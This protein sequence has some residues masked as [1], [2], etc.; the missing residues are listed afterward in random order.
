MRRLLLALMLGALAT[1]VWAQQDQPPLQCRYDASGRVDYQACLDASAPGTPW[2]ML[3]HINLGTRAFLN[4]DHA[5][6]VRH[7]DAAQPGN[8]DTFYSDAEFHAYYA[9]TLHQVGRLDDGVVQARRALAVM[10]ADRSLPSSVR[11]RFSAVPVDRELVYAAIL[12]VLHAAGDEQAEAVRVSYLQMPA[13]DWVSWANR[14][15]VLQQI[16]DLRGALSASEQ[17]LQLQPDHPAVLNNHCYI[18]TLLGRANEALPYCERA[19][20]AAPGIAGAR[21][22]LAS[23]YA[24]LGQ[25]GNARVQLDEARRLDPESEDYRHDLACR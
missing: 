25:C 6:A 9:A 20:E 23:A 10:N 14:A 7:Y 12:P 19:V 2:A 8:G 3:S 1:P 13:V 16:G 15:G 5:T 24:A 17:S 4:A 22:S 18:L 11:D 21:H